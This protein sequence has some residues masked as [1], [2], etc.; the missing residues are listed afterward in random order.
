MIRW[1]IVVFA[2]IALGGLLGALMLRDAGYVLIAYDGA[3]LETSLWFAVAALILIAASAYLLGIV[4][5]ATARGGAGLAAAAA[6]RGQRTLRARAERGAMLLLE[7][8]WAEAER[9]LRETAPSLDVPLLGFVA[10]ARAANEAERF[11]DRDAVLDRAKA[12]LP[13]AAFVLELAR[14]ELQQQAGQWQ[15]SLDTLAGLR[16]EA[17]RHPL[18][19]ARSLAARQALGSCDADGARPRSAG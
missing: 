9:P 1:L 15:A 16:R 11:A 19:E 2:A 13:S 7:G 8:R 5:R 6:K 4:W 10:A 18:V 17:P 12:A 3:T 14:S